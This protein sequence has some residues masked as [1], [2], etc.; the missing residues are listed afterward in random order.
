M[1]DGVYIS[2]I[3]LAILGNLIS[4]IIFQV[5]LFSTPRFES[6]RNHSNFLSYLAKPEMCASNQSLLVL[7][8]LCRPAMFGVSQKAESIKDMWF[9]ICHQ[10]YSD[11]EKRISE[12]HEKLIWWQRQVLLN[13]ISSITVEV[14]EPHRRRSTLANEEKK[15]LCQKSRVT[16]LKEGNINSA[17]FQSIAVFPFYFFFFVNILHL[18]GQIWTAGIL[19]L[20]IHPTVSLLLTWEK[21]KPRARASFARESARTFKFHGINSN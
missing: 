3:L 5:I 8:P 19:S 9:K 20:E 4:R 11:L 18:L 6:K 10:N 17:Y 13:H 2:V 15:F 12:A 7:S 21:R 16:W 14:T 1:A